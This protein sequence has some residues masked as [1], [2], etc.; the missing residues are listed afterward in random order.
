MAIVRSMSTKEGDHERG[1]YLVKTGYRPEPAVIHPSL[2]RRIV[3]VGGVEVAGE[4]P[5]GLRRVAV[6]AMFSS[7]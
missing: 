2:D 6:V 7:L 5:E 3:F 1:T 4:E